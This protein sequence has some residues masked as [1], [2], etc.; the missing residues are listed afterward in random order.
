LMLWEPYLM[1]HFAIVATSQ[2]RQNHRQI[3]SWF[4]CFGFISCWAISVHRWVPRKLWTF[5]E[6]KKIFN[7]E[8]GWWSRLN[9]SFVHHTHAGQLIMT[10]YVIHNEKWFRSDGISPEK[11][12]FPRVKEWVL[13]LLFGGRLC[14]TWNNPVTKLPGFT[15]YLC[16]SDTIFESTRGLPVR[17]ALRLLHSSLQTESISWD[18]FH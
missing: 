6:L 1:G 18:I 3:L 15:R 7:R 12:P 5:S 9:E 17:W 16:K 13:F 10:T 2:T 11:E 14:T 8:V 4:D